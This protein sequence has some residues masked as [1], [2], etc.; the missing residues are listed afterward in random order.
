MADGPDFGS[1]LHSV[2]FNLGV[3][4]TSI[5]RLADQY[6]QDLDEDSSTLQQENQQLV[7]ELDYLCRILSGGNAQLAVSPPLDTGGDEVPVPG[8]ETSEVT[9][10]PSGFMQGNTNSKI[11]SGSGKG[12]NLLAASSRGSQK[13]QKVEKE[14]MQSQ[15][16]SYNSAVAFSASNT[17][18]PSTASS[19]ATGTASFGG[20][21][22]IKLWDIWD[23]APEGRTDF[24]QKGDK[25][26]RR[27]A[28]ASS[29]RDPGDPLAAKKLRGPICSQ[30][31]A[32]P[33]SMRRLLWD[34]IGMGLIGYDL[35]TIP[36]Q[37]FDVPPN[38][39]F[40]MMAWL[41]L[42]FWTADIPMTFFVG[43]HKE[44]V[45]E[46]RAVKIAKHYFKTWFFFDLTVVGSDWWVTLSGYLSTG[47]DDSSKGG[48]NVGF[49]RLGKTARF[50]RVLR[51]L[52][53][54]KLH[55]MIADIFERIQSE[56]TRI[57][58]GIVN[59]IIFI[60]LINHVI[61]CL[62]YGIGVLD[63]SWEDTWVK[64]NHL[65]DESLDYRYTTA[66][67]WSLTQFTPASMEVVPTNSL[68]R[69]YTVCT[70]LFAMVT[71]S[72]FVSSITNAMTQLRNLDSGRI[73][74]YATLRRYLKENRVHAGLNNQ[75]WGWLQHTQ[76]T[77]RH[78]LH[79]EAVS[80]LQ[81]LP[82]S[83]QFEL[84]QE[85]YKPILCQHPFFE[86][87]FEYHPVNRKMFA[88]LLEVS[89]TV[90]QELFFAGE[91]ATQMSLVINGI[92]SYTM[93][94]DGYGTLESLKLKEGQWVCEPILWIEWKHCGQLTAL[95]HCEFIAV[96]ARPFQELMQREL[97][98][99]WQA[100]LYA[101]LWV[102]YIIDHRVNVN[103]VWT[104]LDVLQDLATAVFNGEVPSDLVCN[105]ACRHATI[106]LSR[107]N[108]GDHDAANDILDEKR[109]QFNSNRSTF[110]PH[111]L[112]QMDS[113]LSA[114]WHMSASNVSSPQTGS[115]G[116]QRST[117]GHVDSLPTTTSLA[118]LAA[119][120]YLIHRQHS[121]TTFKIATDG[122]VQNAQVF[123]DDRLRDSG[124]QDSAV[125]EIGAR[126]LV[127]RALP[128]RGA[129]NRLAPRSSGAAALPMG[130]AA[131]VAKSPRPPAANMVEED[132]TSESTAGSQAGA[133]SKQAA[134]DGMIEIRDDITRPPRDLTYPNFTRSKATTPPQ[135]LFQRLG[136]NSS[137]LSKSSIL[138]SI[139][140]A[141][142]SKEKSNSE[143]PNSE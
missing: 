81:L 111:D 101:K 64:A 33:S 122:N 75:I 91:K 10:V 120:G 59:L 90:G 141:L 82:K 128:P 137:M 31:I 50:L 142:H 72:S 20:P 70:L 40:T 103:D 30:M 132:Y 63:D 105:P 18:R 27:M 138:S 62:F 108:L 127:P 21:W 17:R 67:H 61:A 68:E 71:F 49:L 42:L 93:G 6:E 134:L 118:R 123:S 2:S 136:S 143:K 28:A 16:N 96:S 25:R 24:L 140:K 22:G 29:L 88:C 52:R 60:M 8:F 130:N 80:L 43:F 15:M 1:L 113:K 26:L 129:I 48:G 95:T 114:S 34:V 124:V 53:L 35:I 69:S 107:A 139:S 47:D 92:S 125:Q 110:V 94:E 87:F 55:G 23:E 84:Q 79:E 13:W 97:V 39:V 14:L 65:P 41:T 54:L 89:V 102:K 7:L 44:G 117:I 133:R 126:R 135:G 85:I 131:M 76:D 57:M 115:V 45:V 116:P 36:M 106:K 77:A 56:F 38:F 78:R 83:L 99:A 46:M 51:L 9:W 119:K 12:F 19:S 3:L 58:L 98:E 4:C 112:L 5:S 109:R 74:Q 73:L 104:D 32:R 86:K 66:L 121:P 100:A 37:A 11:S